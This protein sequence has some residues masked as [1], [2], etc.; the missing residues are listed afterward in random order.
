MYS[1]G[2]Y[3]GSSC[4]F[5]NNKTTSS[6]LIDKFMILWYTNSVRKQVKGYDEDGAREEAPQRVRVWC[7]RMASISSPI[8]SEPMLRSRT[9][10]RSVRAAALRRKSGRGVVS[11]QH[12]WYREENHPRLMV[13]FDRGAFFV[14][15]RRSKEKINIQRRKKT[16]QRITPNR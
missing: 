5:H 13:R 1:V 4:L 10:G 11:L 15:N 12:E 3:A 9:E 6:K 14:F 7:E 2:L 8:T 16:W